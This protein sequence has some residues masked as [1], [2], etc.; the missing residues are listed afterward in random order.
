MFGGSFMLAV[1]GSY[2]LNQID[3]MKIEDVFPS[4]RCSFIPMI[5]C[6]EFGEKFTR[7][8]RF[9]H[10]YHHVIL[11]IDMPQRTIQAFKF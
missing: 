2:T 5:P 4:V 9:L 8:P 11:D 10:K 7:T 3:A 6:F 1:E